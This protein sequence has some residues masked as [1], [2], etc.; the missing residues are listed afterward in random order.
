MST[1][2]AIEADVSQVSVLLSALRS[3][4]PKNLLPDPGPVMPIVVYT[5]P[6]RTPGANRHAR[7]GA[8]GG[9]SGQKE[10]EAQGGSREQEDRLCGR[11][12]QVVGCQSVGCKIVG[13][14]AGGRQENRHRAGGRKKSRGT[15]R[16]E[17]GRR[18]AYGSEAQRR[19]SLRQDDRDCNSG[20]QGQNRRNQCLDANVD[21]GARGKPAARFETRAPAA[22]PAKKASAVNFPQ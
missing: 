4:T 18:E 20:P 2:M 11:G 17:K 10:I 15:C 9:R 19:Q 8:R 22:P 6:T 12:Y 14:R 1:A 7:R 13:R 3:P 21:L 16:Q 5:G